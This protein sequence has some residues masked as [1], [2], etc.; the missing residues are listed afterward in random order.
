MD[1]SWSLLVGE[2][3]L[4]VRPATSADLALV[5]KTLYTALSWDPD[6]PIPPFEAVVG[7]PKIAIYHDG[8]M[9][10]GD[11][12]VVAETRSGGFVGM[13]YCRQFNH[14]AEAQGFVDPETPE[15]AVGVEPGF[16]NRGV[17]ECLIK[18][19]HESRRIVGVQGMSLSASAGNRAVKLYER[20][21]YLV[22]RRH[23]EGIVMF[24]DIT[25]PA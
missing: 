2:N 9:R 23:D 5:Q 22:V 19:L 6:D 18:R 14:G 17:G 3:R 8:W 24:A 16:R 13:A 12:G 7:H 4:R 1:T 20:L 10:R 11:D 21:G 25:K 15:M